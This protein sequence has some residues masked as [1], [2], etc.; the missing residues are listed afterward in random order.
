M[1]RTLKGDTLDEIVADF[2]TG[3]HLQRKWESI[4]TPEARDLVRDDYE[5]TRKFFERLAAG[6]KT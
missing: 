2:W 1:V 4:T 5:Y 6:L 3:G